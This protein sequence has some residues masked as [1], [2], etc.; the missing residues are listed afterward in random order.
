MGRAAKRIAPEGLL[1]TFE[2][3]MHLI[4]NGFPKLFFMELRVSPSTGQIPLSLTL[5]WICGTIPR[6]SPARALDGT[7]PISGVD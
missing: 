5:S 4:L 7:I 6:C 1:D 2:I 3:L